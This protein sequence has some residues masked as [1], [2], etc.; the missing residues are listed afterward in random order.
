MALVDGLGCWFEVFRPAG[1][2]GRRPGLFLDRDGV[3]VE[4]PGYLGRAEDVVMIAGAAT[5]IARFNRLE[6]PVVLVTNQAGVARGYYGWDGFQDVQSEITKALA[7]EG[8]WLDAVAACAFH[9][10]GGGPLSVTDHPWRKPAPGMLL[11]AAEAL[12]LALDR[13]WIVGDKASDLGA[14]VAAGLAG[15]THVATGHGWLA[16]ERQAAQSMHGDHFVVHVAS[17]FPDAA[18]VLADAL[19]R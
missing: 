3:V 11:A 9:D 2:R 12:D 10:V 14:G 5:A 1:P 6:I 13:S 7:A 15:G 18:D 8:A 4:E 17:S 19:T 16:E